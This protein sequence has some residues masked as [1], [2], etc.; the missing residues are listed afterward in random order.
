MCVLPVFLHCFIFSI[1]QWD[2]NNDGD[3]D[4]GVA[5]TKQKT[6]L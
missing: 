5:K 4:G 6:E 2:G 3:D 1:I